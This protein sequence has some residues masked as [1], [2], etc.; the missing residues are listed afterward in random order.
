MEK[1]LNLDFVNKVINDSLLWA[2]ENV[3][4]LENLIQ[5]GILILIVPFSLIIGKK[6]KKAIKENINFSVP[7]QFKLK[8]I[9]NELIEIIPLL[10]L[11]F[12]FWA[13]GIILKEMDLGFA[14]LKI[15]QTFV[16][17]W[18][19]IKLA[20]TVIS[21]KFWAKVFTVSALVIAVFHILGLLVPVI[22]LLDNIGF[23]MGG[24]RLTLLSVFKAIILIFALLKLGTWVSD[25]LEKKIREVDDLTPSAHVLVSKIIKISIIGL[26][27]IVSL[28]SIGIDLSA[29]AVFGGMI[30]VGIGFGLQK[31]VANFISGIIL[32]L[33]KSIK[34]GDVIEIGDVYGWVSDFKAR[35][36]SVVTRDGKEYLIPNEDMITQQV[37]NW[38]YSTSQIRVRIPVGV[39]YNDDVHLARKLMLESIK[40]IDRVLTKPEAACLLKGFGD[41]SVDFELRFWIK[42]PQNGLANIRSVVMLNIWDKFKQNNIEIPYPQR[43]VHIDTSEPIKV[44]AVPVDS[45]EN[46]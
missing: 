20:A 39:S 17:A 32:L 21:D 13:A 42:D 1:I 44:E 3:F 38:S 27:C 23:T 6:I 10:S 8:I 22:T 40:G 2:K 30:G 16:V 37:I 12:F 26:V 46:I 41:N 15:F 19:W 45:R 4:I 35:Y 11:A 33:D 31:V 7:E 14:F 28:T 29:F 36:A 24:V 43:D 5:V 9:L 34:P 25:Q 18:I